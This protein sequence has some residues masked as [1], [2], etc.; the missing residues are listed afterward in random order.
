MSRSLFNK[1]VQS[2]TSLSRCAGQAFTR[3]PVW[4]YLS[5]SQPAAF[6]VQ[7]RDSDIVPLRPREPYAYLMHQLT[8]TAHTSCF[9]RTLYSVP[10][11]AH[12]A[13]LDRGLNASHLD[14][15]HKSSS[16]TAMTTER[17]SS[18]MLSSSQ[19]FRGQLPMSIADNRSHIAPDAFEW[20][21]VRKLNERHLL[22]C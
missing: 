6:G 18:F 16:Y 14:S 1:T 5:F 4:F 22:P 3:H 21:A 9:P 2:L 19:W 17:L 8:T 7:Y 11:K 15:L 12:Q 20:D 13:F 10:Y